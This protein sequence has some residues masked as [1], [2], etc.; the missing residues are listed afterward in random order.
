VLADNL[1][2]GS[3]LVLGN[4]SLVYNSDI[5]YNENDK[6][7]KVSYKLQ[8]NPESDI[9][10]TQSDYERFSDKIKEEQA[11]KIRINN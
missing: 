1:P 11:I 9:I 4:N 6:A 2:K 5:N 7:L 10:F 8:T 3:H